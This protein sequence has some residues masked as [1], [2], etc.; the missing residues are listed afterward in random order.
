MD[1]IWKQQFIFW[2]VRSSSPLKKKQF[3]ES[4]FLLQCQFNL[5]SNQTV[6][7]PTMAKL[8]FGGVNFDRIYAPFGIDYIFIPSYKVNQNVTLKEL[9]KVTVLV[10]NIVSMNQ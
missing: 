3:K 7:R 1:K 5:V 2:Q 10:R 4:A 8:L 6:S 9:W